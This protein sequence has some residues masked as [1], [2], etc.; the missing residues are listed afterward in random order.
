MGDAWTMHEQALY[1]T[2]VIASD[3]VHRGILPAPMQVPFA[4]MRRD[5]AVWRTGPYR[6]FF[7]GRGDGQGLNLTGVLFPVVG[8]AQVV[9]G[10]NSKDERWRDL[11]AGQIFVGNYGFYLAHPQAPAPLAFSYDSIK[12]ATIAERTLDMVVAMDNG[13]TWQHRI[14]SD[15][16]ELIY[17]GWTMASN[18][19]HP[20]LHNLAW[21][22]RSFIDQVAASM[23]WESSPPAQLVNLA[24]ILTAPPP[25]AAASSSLPAP[26]RGMP[27]PPTWQ[28]D[29]GGANTGGAKGAGDLTWDGTAWR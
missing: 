3:L 8:I 10:K 27:A 18:P 26:P 9:R 29:A 7:F 23:P 6:R 14:E 28:D 22:P 21:L 11:D 24:A 25:P 20:Q 1:E 2:C 5:D 17:I 16:A 19:H 15:W 13:T 12:S 4:L